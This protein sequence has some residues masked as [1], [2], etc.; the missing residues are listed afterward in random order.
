MLAALIASHHFA[1]AQNRCAM[2]LTT[3]DNSQF[4]GWLTQK[5]IDASTSS[6]ARS[7]GGVYTIRVVVHVI[8]RG[9]PIGTGTN[10][11]EP[12]ILSQMEVLNR[13]FN[14]FNNDAIKTPEE[15]KSIAGSMVIEFKL[16]GINRVRGTKTSWTIQDNVSLK[17][18]SYWD[19]EDYLNIWV[20]DLTDY[21]GYTQ[22]PISTLPGLNDSPT[23]RLTDG[24]IVSYRA[25]GSNDYGSFDLKPS[26]N[27]GRTTVHEVGHFLGLR[28]IWGDKVGC[29]GTDYVDDTP[30]QSDKTFG[31]PTHPQVEC[32]GVPKM[33]QNFMDFTDDACMNLFTQ[34]QVNRMV[35]VLENSPRRAS[36]LLP[37]GSVSEINQAPKI[38]SPN[39]DGVN[40]FWKWPDT[41]S[42]TDCTLSI[43]DINGREVFEMKAYDNSW[44]GR[45]RDGQYLEAGAYYYVLKCNG[46]EDVTGGVRI[47]R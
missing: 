45:G 34:G 27:K 38:F 4:E 33:F 23:N 42:Y 3:E 37:L 35:T 12:Q 40:D 28:H 13:D 29:D 44:N 16:S 17:S 36:L 21:F 22:F 31:C 18:Q 26:L 19:A 7:S 43:F 11:S 47:V 30:S 10:L 46:K 25:F 15:F 6:Q 41:S 5:R 8:H 39:G 14:R 24:I 1:N 2:P 20:C 32:F 9:E